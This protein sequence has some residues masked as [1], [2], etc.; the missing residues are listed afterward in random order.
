MLP[1]PGKAVQ[2]ESDSNNQEVI[3]QTKDITNGAIHE[4]SFIN[5]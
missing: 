5:P 4:W 1:Q 2:Y 3:C